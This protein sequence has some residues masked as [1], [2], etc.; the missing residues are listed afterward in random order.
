MEL[1]LGGTTGRCHTWGEKVFLRAVREVR[2]WRLQ[3]PIWSDRER[4]WQ[5]LKLPF[6]LT[7]TPWPSHRHFSEHVPASIAPA[8]NVKQDPPFKDFEKA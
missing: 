1:G 3:A 2:I 6:S 7:L 4:G 5:D 8:V